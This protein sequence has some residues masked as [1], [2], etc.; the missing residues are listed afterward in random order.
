[1]SRHSLPTD[2]IGTERDYSA[3][4]DPAATADIF[5]ADP[6]GTLTGAPDGLVTSR[7]PLLIPTRWRRFL[8]RAWHPMARGFLLTLL[9]IAGLPV[10]A[11]AVSQPS[12]ADA[13][14]GSD[15][16][17][18]V[19]VA[20]TVSV[21]GTVTSLPQAANSDLPRPAPNTLVTNSPTTATVV[22]NAPVLTDQKR[23]RA[24]LICS[25]EAT[26]DLIVT[27]KGEVGLV[28]T[29]AATAHASGDGSARLKVTGQTG[30][31]TVTYAASGGGLDMS[32]SALRGTCSS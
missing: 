21:P 15:S 10:V 5:A 29:G 1:M 6:E 3:H 12:E 14:S 32:W 22:T 31:Y 9:A 7:S 13:V 16:V 20:V 28:V 4:E 23:H 24:L 30:T 17:T 25:T 11:A 19:T 27:G 18:M 2:V 26:L 8:F